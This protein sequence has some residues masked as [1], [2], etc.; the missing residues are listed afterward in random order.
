MLESVPPPPF[1]GP[2]MFEAMF[3]FTLDLIHS[4][5]PKFFWLIVVLLIGGALYLLV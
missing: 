3:D 5:S 4:V 2:H 1:I